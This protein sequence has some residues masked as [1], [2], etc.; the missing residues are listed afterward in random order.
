MLGNI[1][2]NGDS[3]KHNQSVPA[4]IE[5]TVW[6]GVDKSYNYNTKDTWNDGGMQNWGGI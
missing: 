4:F 2:S 3:E 5:P 6:K 1:R